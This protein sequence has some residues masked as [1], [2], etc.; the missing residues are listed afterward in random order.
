[1]HAQ[2]NGK[3]RK[4][5]TAKICDEMKNEKKNKK[6]T[7]K[8]HTNDGHKRQYHT[9]TL[10]PA[11]ERKQKLF[12]Y[13]FCVLYIIYLISSLLFCSLLGF[14]R[15][16]SFKISFTYFVTPLALHRIAA[17]TEI[18]KKKTIHDTNRK[19]FVIAK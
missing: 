10:I 7:K 3:K 19:C 5:K 8:I 17:T 14:R 6:V 11:K 13:I 18:K 15:F 1:M 2:T 9:N 4:E 16:F 12:V